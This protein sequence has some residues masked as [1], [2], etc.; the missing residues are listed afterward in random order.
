MLIESYK[1]KDGKDVIIADLEDIELVK[2]YRWFLK[3]H[4]VIKDT[5]ATG[6]ILNKVEYMDYVSSIENIK[7][8]LKNA[9]Q[10]RGIVMSKILG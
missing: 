7:L 3:Y 1:D 2:L 9:V 4:N 6:A 5:L 8:S 10:K